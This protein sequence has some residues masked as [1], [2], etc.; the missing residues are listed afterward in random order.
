[1]YAGMRPHAAAGRP[2]RDQPPAAAV[3][4]SLPR[5]DQPEHLDEAGHDPDVLS[6]SLAHVAQVNRWLGGRRA[7][8]L[9]VAQHLGGAGRMLD[10]GTGAGDLPM[11]LAD[12]AGRR[13][14]R[15]IIVADDR[16]P[17]ILAVAAR[18]AAGR[19]GLSFA[20]ADALALPF[21][22]RAFDVVLLSMVLHHLDDQAAS[23]ALAE[24]A[25]VAPL[26]I[27]NELHRTR[28][29]YAGARLLAATLWRGNRLTRHD[30]PLSVLRAYRPGELRA[31][32]A[33]A[34][35]TVVE[36]R[37]RWFQRVVLV[38]AAPSAGLA[39]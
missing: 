4:R 39:P 26:V 37:R 29:N 3:I 6:A 32:A 35:L 10:V 1:M 21:P 20:G 24:A 5:A 14:G 31:L 27:V 17:Q 15:P 30:G 12:L 7:V 33:A 2:A 11:V 18:R 25:R 9:A 13:D 38:A 8:R 34:G 22:D 23:R 36:L 16:H 19:R 28:T